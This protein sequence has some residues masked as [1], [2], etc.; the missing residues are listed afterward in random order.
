M[1]D[2]LVN[3]IGV[4]FWPCKLKKKNQ[5]FTSRPNSGPVFLTNFYGCV[6]FKDIHV[7]DIW[8]ENIYIKRIF[9][10]VF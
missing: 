10:L 3:G 2:L 4:E 6:Q 8:A 7:I 9:S 5:E 1:A